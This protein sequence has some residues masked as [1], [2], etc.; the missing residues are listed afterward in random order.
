[1]KIKRETC[2][3]LVAGLLLGTAMLIGTAFAGEG[4]PEID[5][6]MVT[7]GLTILGV[8]IVLVI[9]RYRSRP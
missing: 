4:S 9:E 1:M 5:P 3:G 8:G 6:G 2:R 7:G